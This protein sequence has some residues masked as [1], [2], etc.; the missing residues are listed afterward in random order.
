MKRNYYLGH[1]RDSSQNAGRFSE[2]ALRFIQCMVDGHYS[3]LDK[4]LPNFHDEVI[5]FERSPAT[6]SETLRIFIPRTL[7][8]V[9]DIRNKRDVG[10]PK[11]EL[12]AN[13]TDATLAYYG[14]SW[15]LVELVRLFYTNDIQEAQRM[16]DD[17]MEFPVPV[18]QN[19]D[20]FLKVLN[21]ELSLDD[22]ILL[23]AFYKRD[24]IFIEDVMKWTYGVHRK[25]YVA[26]RLDLLVQEKSYLHQDG[27]LVYHITLTGIREIVRKQL[28]G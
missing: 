21:P 6:V 22:K 25:N 7:D 3:S 26:K 28:I 2:I 5:R 14:A 11:G 27:D 18:I 9:H 10:H 8:I 1:Y 4:N 15:V 23:F 19:F 12:D 16:I 20:G 24:G 17:L 13:Y